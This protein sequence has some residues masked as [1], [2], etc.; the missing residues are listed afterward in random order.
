MKNTVLIAILVGLVAG[1]A[2]FYG[3]IRYTA[4]RRTAG[5]R[6]GTF[7]GA[8]GPQGSGQPGRGAFRQMIGNG[9]RPVSGEIKSVDNNT[10][11]VQLPDGSSKIVVFSDST[12]IAKN[13][14]GSRSDLKVGERVTAIGSQ[15]S[16]GTL[17]ATN[18]SIGGNFFIGGPAASPSPAGK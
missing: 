14:D 3:G 6:N 13:T 1:S 10:L 17:S 15:G 4:M 7:Q 5:F 8:G 2:G 18:L 12:K 11:T 16:D 9:E